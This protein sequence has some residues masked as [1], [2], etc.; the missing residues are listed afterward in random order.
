MN[1]VQTS[2]VLFSNIPQDAEGSVE[3]WMVLA[4]HYIKRPARLNPCRYTSVEYSWVHHGS[5]KRP[6]LSE[7]SCIF[8]ECRVVIDR[9]V[10]QIIVMGGIA[11]HRCTKKPPETKIFGKAGML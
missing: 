2:M 9:M 6:H 10:G 3:E 4:G 8:C 7:L 5:T 1:M 11:R